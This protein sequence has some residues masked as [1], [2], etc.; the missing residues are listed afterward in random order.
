MI[1][2]SSWISFR[3][4]PDL[5]GALAIDPDL[6]SVM[7]KTSV[8]AAAGDTALFAAV[9]ELGIE[10]V[11]EAD[12]RHVTAL[13]SLALLIAGEPSLATNAVARLSSLSGELLAALPG[14][15]EPPCRTGGR[16]VYTRCIH[17]RKTRARI[18]AES[19]VWLELARMRGTPN[20]DMHICPTPREVHPR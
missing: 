15:V 14:G 2:A 5:G 20:R 13:R 8:I 12:E 1:M 19:K 9:A 7:R 10:A 11:E 6:W 17:A 18:G 3:V 16:E 4:A